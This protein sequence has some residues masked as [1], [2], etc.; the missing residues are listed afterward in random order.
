MTVV[1]VATYNLY[2]GADLTLVFG[3]ESPDHLLRQAKL[4]HDQLQATDFASRAVAIAALLEREQVDVVGLQEV[5]RWS[6]ARLGPD[7]N[8]GEAEV[9]CDFLE[10]LLAALERAGAPYD[11]HAPNANFNGGAPI[12]GDEAMSVV[13]HNVILV[14]RG[15]GVEVT[16]TSTGDYATLLE[17][18]TGMRELVLEVGRG[19]GWVD[20]VVD[21]LPFRFVNTHTE[22]YDEHTRNAQRDELLAA[23]GDPGIPV[24]IAG[25]FNARPESVGMP[26]EYRDAWVAGRGEGERHTCCQ[27]ADLANPESALRE[28][29]DYLWVRGAEVRSCR[30]V[31]NTATDRTA[32]TNLW[33][34]DH[35]CVLADVSL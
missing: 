26:P 8:A 27:G 23:I 25:D 22:A 13:G 2:L 7:G 33:P 30:V 20:G 24:V 1:R 34:S 28:R 9:C 14:R 21:G 31:G 29:I 18:P 17:I 15:S 4:V 12:S 5:A 3:V 10:E 16:A 11:A 32:G 19:W 6:N 35:A